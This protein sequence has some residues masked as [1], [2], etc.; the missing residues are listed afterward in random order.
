M[1]NYVAVLMNLVPNANIRYTGVEVPYE[2]IEWLDD[3]KQPTKAECDE[4][5]PQVN[6]ELTVASLEAQRQ[7]RY[8][9]ETDG[10]FFDAMRGDQDLTQWIVGVEAIKAE[11]P[12]PETPV[13]DNGGN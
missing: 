4:A 13:V 12:Y 2:S 10:V 6:Y 1:T 11:L 5:W 3:R 7:S 9:R 8:V